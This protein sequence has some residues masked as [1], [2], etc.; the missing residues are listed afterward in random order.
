MSKRIESGLIFT[1]DP[2]KTYI[3][4]DEDYHKKMNSVKVV[5]FIYCLN[6]SMLF[7]EAKT[8]TPP[9]DSVT[10][11][12]EKFHDSLMM[13]LGAYFNRTRTPGE[14]LP[15]AFRNRSQFRK[16][17]KMLVVVKK[18]RPEWFGFISSLIQSEFISICQTFSID[19]PVIIHYSDL[20]EYCGINCRENK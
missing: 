3:I 6:D 1:Y 15:R 13:L 9:E 17:I 14:N 7:I 19:P 5:D 10:A 2:N 8:N 18:N 12:R 11:I 20:K 16:K 4:E